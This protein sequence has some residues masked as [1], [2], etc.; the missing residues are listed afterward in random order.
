MSIDNCITGRERTALLVISGQL[1]GDFRCHFYIMSTAI[2]AR[3]L[4]VFHYISNKTQ[5]HNKIKLWRRAWLCAVK[6]IKLSCVGKIHS[7]R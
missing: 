1:V 5:V 6:I 3:L 2:A 4:T 7:E